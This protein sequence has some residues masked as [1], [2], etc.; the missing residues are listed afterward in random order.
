LGREKCEESMEG[1]DMQQRFHLRQQEV[2]AA[3][4]L[5]VEQMGPPDL[6]SRGQK[7]VAAT[8]IGVDFGRTGPLRK[9][10]VLRRKR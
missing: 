7:A 4:S 3:V 9:M 10:A 6:P 1:R 5:P 8:H 2:K